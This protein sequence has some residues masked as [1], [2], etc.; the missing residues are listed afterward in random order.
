LGIGADGEKALPMGVLR[1]GAR[2]IVL[3]PGGG[4]VNGLDDRAGTDL[5]FVHS[6]R[7][8]DDGDCVDGIGG[9]RGVG[10]GE[11]LKRH[12][13]IDGELLRGEDAVE[14]F[15]RKSALA[16]EEVGDMGLSE[17]GLSRETG[18]GESS[19]FDPTE[20]FETE[21]LVEILKIHR[22]EFFLFSNHIILQDEI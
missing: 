11:E 7:G 14:A 16:I 10:C 13:L 21:K 3:K 18:S 5:G 19:K 22:A 15:E 2:T 8:R 12:D 1:V 17:S 20:E 6:G 9:G 4:D